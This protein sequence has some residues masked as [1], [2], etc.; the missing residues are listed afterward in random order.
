MPTPWGTITF[1]SM[2]VSMR[3]SLVPCCTNSDMKMWSML[4]YLTNRATSR[5]NLPYT[6]SSVTT[7]ALL[8]SQIACYHFTAFFDTESRDS[9]RCRMTCSGLERQVSCLTRNCL[10]GLNTIFGFCS[11]SAL[12]TSNSSIAVGSRKHWCCFGLS[13]HDYPKHYRLLA[14]YE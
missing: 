2:D 6:A 14:K 11:I 3:R 1:I 10:R 13:A 4:D 8:Q 7:H 9:C 12:P 5:E